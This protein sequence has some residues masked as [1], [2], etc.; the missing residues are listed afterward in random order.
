MATSGGGTGFG[1]ASP[2][3][4]RIEDGSTNTLAVV[5]GP[6]DALPGQAGLVTTSQ[7]MAFNDATNNWERVRSITFVS[8]LASAA[9]T[10]TTASADQVNYSARGVM[11]CLNVTAASGTGGLQVRLIY[12]DLISGGGAFVGTPP[13]AIV[14][15]GFYSYIFYP[16]AGLA[17]IAGNQQVNGVLSAPLPRNWKASIQHGDASSYT[18]S[19]EAGYLF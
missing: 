6:N 5:S 3:Y 15:T 1:L 18:Y 12:D 7:D 13:T 17:A 8:L 4:I 14:A 19:V 10:A 9:R 16:G 2:G 11:V